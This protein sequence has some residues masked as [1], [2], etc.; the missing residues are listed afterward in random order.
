M[1]KHTKYREKLRPN[2]SILIFESVITSQHFQLALN[3]GKITSVTKFMTTEGV[4]GKL[5]FCGGI[6]NFSL[7]K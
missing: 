6:I 3:R 4:I 7:E 1:W 2:T 5:P